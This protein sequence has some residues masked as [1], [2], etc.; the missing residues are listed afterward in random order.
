MILVA[1]GTGTLGSA[2]VAALL[3]RGVPVR[4]LTRDAQRAAGYDGRVETC[5]GDVRNPADMDRAVRGCATVVSAVQG[6]AGTDPAGPS[7]VD[8]Q[9]NAHLIRAAAA[10]GVDHFVLVSV[11][12]AAP[13]HPMELH[14]CKYRAEQEL[15]ASGLNATIVRPTAFME[16]W[17]A[18][19][20]QPITDRGTAVVFGR[21][22]NPINFVSVRDVAALVELAVRNPQLRGSEIDIGGPADLT[23]NQLTSILIGTRSVPIRHIPR[24]VMRL[25]ATALRPVRPAVARLIRAGIVMDTTNMT[26]SPAT[27]AAIPDIPTT[28]L[29]DLIA[30]RA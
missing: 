21:G 29:A 11:H 18:T 23:L 16:T 1:G 17:I 8:H 3:V 12:D 9:G 2:V 19:L 28:A 10:S 20:G 5:V 15:A 26:L 4:V 24:P 30:V 6:F 27:R 13:R 14:R 7:A 25:A 22:D